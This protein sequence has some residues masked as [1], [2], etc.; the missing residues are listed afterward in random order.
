MTSAASVRDHVEASILLCLSPSFAVWAVLILSPV[1]PPCQP[2]LLRRPPPPRPF[3]L[4]VMAE[5]DASARLRRAV[6]G[7]S[8]RHCLSN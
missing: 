7:A 2:V 5:K 3:L 4:S 1:R 8:V 6:K